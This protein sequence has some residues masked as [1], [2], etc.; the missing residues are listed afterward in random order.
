MAAYNAG[1]TRVNRAIRKNKKAGK[2]TRFWD[3]N[4]PKETTAYVPKLLVLCELIKDPDS[5]DVHLPSIA[6]R[7]YFQKVKIP[8]QL[9][10]MQ[11]A[12]LAGLKPETIYELNPGFNQWATD[13]SGPHY[14]LLPLGV[15]DRFITQLDSLDQDDLVRWDRYKIRRGDNL[16]RIASRYKIE[17]SVLKEINGMSSDLI[18]AGREIMVPRGSAWANKQSPRERTYKVA[19]GD[20]LWDISKKFK[21]SIEDIV[22]WNE[23]KI[24]KPLQINQAIK[25][26]SRYERIR[27]DI[28]SKQ[29]RTMLYPVKSGDTVSRIASKFDITSSQI[30]EW[31]EIKDPSKIFPGQVLKLFL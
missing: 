4:L 26:F 21:V 28:P 20:S 29:L 17:V 24:E 13:P 27:Q 19:K 25:I 16:S 2:P 12:D 14:L 18:I 10:L 30:Q 23:L 7:A 11:A 15:S 6:N 22:L 5:F 8:G 1:P 3:L 9:D 31:N